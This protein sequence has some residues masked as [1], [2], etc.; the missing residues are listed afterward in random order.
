[1]IRFGSSENCN[2]EI[3]VSSPFGTSYV[4]QLNP[5]VMLGINAIKRDKDVKGMMI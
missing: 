2:W 5:S 1:M 4:E 3:I